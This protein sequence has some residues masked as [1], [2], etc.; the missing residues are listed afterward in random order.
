MTPDPQAQDRPQDAQDGPAA[1]ATT[2]P[3]ARPAS[4]DADR[5]AAWAVTPDDDGPA[6]GEPARASL[7]DDARREALQRSAAAAQPTAPAPA[8]A[9]S[10][11]AAQEQAT[12][13]HRPAH[14]AATTAAAGTAAGAASGAAA[15][16]SALPPVSRPERPER[17]GA[18]PRPAARPARPAGGRSRRA[19]LV[20]QRVDPWS[21][22]LFSLVASICVGIVLLVAVTVVYVVLANLGVLASVN[23]LLGEVFGGS[24]P[25]DVVEPVFT[26]GR[27]LGATAV[28]AAV[29]VVLLTALATLSALL[30]NLCAALTGGVEV[31]LGERD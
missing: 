16:T 9:S 29:D 2:D 17:P 6:A 11:P 14:A 10:P 23:N 26:L 22:F 27:V 21:V 8:A 12:T 5:T 19:R 28:L 20:L 7:D 24:G 30:Y 18:E 4:E 13:Q 31:V 25:D 15:R 3:S 1:G